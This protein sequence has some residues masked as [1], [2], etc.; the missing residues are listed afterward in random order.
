[1]RVGSDERLQF[2]HSLRVREVI[3]SMVS[4]CGL[5]LAMVSAP[6]PGW[7]TKLSLPGPPNQTE[8]VWFKF[9]AGFCASVTVTSYDCVYVCP[10]A[11]SI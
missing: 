6:M 8:T 2:L 3:E 11:R 7:K 10:D 5:K 4:C 9:S 1:M